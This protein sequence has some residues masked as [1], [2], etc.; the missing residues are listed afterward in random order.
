MIELLWPAAVAGIL[1]ALTAGPLGTLV[2]WQR[3]AY[4]GDTLAHSALLGAA[5][6]LWLHIGVW[7]STA[8]VCAVLAILLVALQRYS[9]LASD[10][11]LG[12]LSHSALALGVLALGLIPSVRIDLNSYLFGDL[13]AVM[14]RD[15]AVIAGVTLAVGAVLI[16]I[17]DRLLAITVHAELAAVEGLPV[18]TLRMAQMVLM[19]LLVAVAMKVVGALL[20][21]ALLIIPASSAQA[22]AR[23]PEQMAVL[24]AGAGAVSVIAGLLLAV[25]AD[26]PVGPAIVVASALLFAVSRLTARSQEY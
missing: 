26:L 11:L 4:F 3:L 23:S 25:A 1:V 7:W 5:L 18:T 16:W 10:S 14:P 2:V 20:V 24:A 13:L 21:T 12:I 22:W 15:V 19:A 9:N 17:W 8:A 6:G